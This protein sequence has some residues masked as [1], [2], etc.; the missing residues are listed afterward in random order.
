MHL[1]KFECAFMITARAIDTRRDD[2]NFWRTR[3][4]EKKMRAAM[5]CLHPSFTQTEEL[6]NTE[7]I[8]YHPYKGKNCLISQHP[9]FINLIPLYENLRKQIY[10]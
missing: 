9:A 2:G 8:D 1:I 10:E 6:K 7:L 4:P 5:D 3:C